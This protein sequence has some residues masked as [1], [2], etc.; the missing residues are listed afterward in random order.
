VVVVDLF[1]E[2]LGDLRELK[3]PRPEAGHHLSAS[4]QHAEGGAQ[5]HV[6]V[7]VALVSVEGDF[8]AAVPQPRGLL[9]YARRHTGK[10][11]RQRGPT[12]A[13]RGKDNHV[14]G[15][16]FA[17]VADDDVAVAISLDGD[18]ADAEVNL[19]GPA[20]DDVLDSGAVDGVHG[21]GTLNVTERGAVGA[22]PRQAGRHGETKRGRGVRKERLEQSQAARVQQVHVRSLRDANGGGWSF[23]EDDDVVTGF[24]RDAGRGAA[25]E[26][27]ADDD[28]TQGGGRTHDAGCS[29][30]AMLPR[31]AHTIADAVRSW[32]EARPDHVAL[33]APR[34]PRRGRAR[35]KADYDV[36]TSRALIDD[37]GH[38]R[39]G[40]RRAGVRVGERVALLVP[41]GPDLTALT[42]ALFDVGAVPVMVD[43]GIGLRGVAA[44]LAQA[45]PTTFIGTR[46]AHVARLVFGWGRRT[47]AR[48]I[49][50]GGGPGT[51]LD[52]IRRLGADA[53]DV[54][55]AVV[56]DPNA[57]AAIAFT[58]GSTGPAKG[59]CYAHRHFFGIYGALKATVI[60]DDVTSDFPT[61]PLFSLFDPA[62]GLTTVVPWMDFTRPARVDP[63]E[64]L[65]PLA[66][67]DVSM[68][69]GSPAL[70][71]TV[72]RF[73]DAHPSPV[74]PHLRTVVSA[75]A[76]VPGTVIRRFR[77]VMAP[78][79][80][81][82]TPYGATEC[83][84][85]A[86]LDDAAILNET[87]ARTDDGEGVCV[88]R[89]APGVQVRIVEIVDGPLPTMRD[90]AEVAPGEVGEL[91]VAGDRCTEAYLVPPSG[92]GV[93]HNPTAKVIDTDTGTIWHRLGDVGWR[94]GQ[95]RLWY[96]GRKA[97]R[98]VTTT[99]AG[100]RIVRY[101]E[102]IE[103]V[104]NL[105]PAVRR[106]ALVGVVRNGVTLPVVC[107][108]L[109][110]GRW[111]WPSVVAELRERA[112]AH[113]RTQGLVEFVRHPGFPVH[114]RHNAKIGRERLAQWAATKK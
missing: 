61:F 99:P 82:L 89:E 112:A 5:E 39:R 44:C 6:A 17:V 64:V 103:P 42:F 50:V 58:S 67:F 8:G 93:D 81:V 34:G 29:V 60:D 9:V 56:S 92:L 113:P 85:V 79:A 2:V 45:E 109:R 37:I 102:A 40:L 20:G 1:V 51:T 84:P 72:G 36:V 21:G 46:L 86:V 41:P 25:D 52:A 106:T 59:V 78:S 35:T 114:V 70:L 105:H 30:P 13:P 68:M 76:P 88:G 62:L 97:H 32:A 16:A 95:G 107:V 31:A 101:T 3:A 96:L 11:E 57:L 28:D 22:D 77:Q 54:D 66:L 14:G 94:D 27:A 65:E 91:L 48:H 33:Y 53:R 55:D 110:P 104:L 7:V 69:F 108:E 111:S 26:A 83:L 4:T 23:L 73:V 71:D 100:E 98:V 38:F 49:F 90:A 19:A 80:R 87:Q 24:M 12:V 63:L 18:D 15:K 74:L 10:R 47:L 75:G 43:P